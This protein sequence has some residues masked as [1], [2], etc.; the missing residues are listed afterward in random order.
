M[1]QIR[2][3]T[4]RCLDCHD[5]REHGVLCDCGCVPR[6]ENEGILRLEGWLC[7][8]CQEQEVCDG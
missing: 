7:V 8:Q 4:D 6:V 3:I 5:D 1:L 2:T